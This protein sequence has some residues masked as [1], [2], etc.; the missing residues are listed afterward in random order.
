[1]PDL[2]ELETDLEEL[3]SCY[4]EFAELVND[5]Q[6][7]IDTMQKNVQTA[8]AHVETAVTEIHVVS[9]SSSLPACLPLSFDSAGSFYRGWAKSKSNHR[10][11]I[12]K[13]APG[14]NFA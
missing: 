8:N 5:Q 6:E 3:H 10:P 11:T 13:K 7:S 4:V 14:K 9:A 2:L 12:I 1:M